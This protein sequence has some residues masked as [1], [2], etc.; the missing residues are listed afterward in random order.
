MPALS[1][2]VAAAGGDGGETN[3]GFGGFGSAPAPAAPAP[4][5][6]EPAAAAPAVP[7]FLQAA[8]IKA[9]SGGSGDAAGEQQQ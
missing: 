6:A 3:I 4:A 8:S 2:L 9:V 5:A 1:L 7:A